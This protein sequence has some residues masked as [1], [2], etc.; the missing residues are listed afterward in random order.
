MAKKSYKQRMNEKYGWYADEFEN[1]DPKI[2]PAEE[3]YNPEPK[4]P[5]TPSRGSLAYEI[6]L[7]ADDEPIRR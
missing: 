6:I 1:P 3:Q 4:H 2:N 5:K 7:E